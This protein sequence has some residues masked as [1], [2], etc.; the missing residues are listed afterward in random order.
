MLLRKIKKMNHFF[1]STST[2]FDNDLTMK[3]IVSLC[4]FYPCSGQLL[5][6]QLRPYCHAHMVCYL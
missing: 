5:V 4:Y 6:P 1:N 2:N 3:D